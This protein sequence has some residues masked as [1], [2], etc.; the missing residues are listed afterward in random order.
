[1][2]Q[3]AHSPSARHVLDTHHETSRRAG[4]Q[5]L[6]V[7][8]GLVVYS[9]ARGTAGADPRPALD[10]ARDVAALEQ[11]LGIAWEDELQRLVVEHDVLVDAANSFY[12]WAHWPLLAGTLLWLLQ[13]HRDA[14]HTTRNALLLSCFVALVVYTVY[15]VAPPR[16]AGVG[17][18]DSVTERS[19][20][21]RVLQPPGMTN[22]YAAMPSLH[23]GW[24]LLVA[25][26]LVQQCA[27]RWVRAVALL[28]PPL[29]LAAIVL[30]ANH[31]FLDAVAGAVVALLG[32][33]VAER[34]RG[35]P[36]TPV[37]VPAPRHAAA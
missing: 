26:A 13:W 2:L 25:I 37:V 31:W 34:L 29:M 19:H 21:Y 35:S 32:L 17:M 33:A 24:D 36:P 6:V 12:V 27:R 23:M 18:V 11:R 15:P 9:L 7:V 3:L 16:L 30:T 22:Q 4:A 28:L 14:F 5:V 10:H 8:A 1:M 20:A